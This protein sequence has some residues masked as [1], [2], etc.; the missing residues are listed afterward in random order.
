MYKNKNKI[1]GFAENSYWTL[2]K[3]DGNYDMQDEAEKSAYSLNMPNGI[4]TPQYKCYVFYAR[5]I[6][7]L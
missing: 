7:S 1:G 4:T 2:S 5:A 3:D 6:R